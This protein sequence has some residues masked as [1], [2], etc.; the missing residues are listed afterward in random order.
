MVTWVSVVYVYMRKH[1]RLGGIWGHAP[2]GNFLKLDALRML[3]RPFWDRRIAVVATWLAEYC[4]QFLAVHACICYANWLRIST[5]EGT[6]V[7]RTAGGVT[8]LEGQL[9]TSRAPEIAIYLRT[10]LRASFHRSGVNSLRAHSALVLREQT[11]RIAATRLVWTVV[12]LNSSETSGPL[13]NGRALK[14][15]S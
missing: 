3:L 14:M 1:A 12:I 4:I 9:V 7:D 11:A 13:S 6:K 15:Y 8:S 10:Y 2:P 5:R